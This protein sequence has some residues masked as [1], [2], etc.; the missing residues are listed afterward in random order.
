MIMFMLL[1]FIPSNIRSG[2]ERSEGT[3]HMARGKFI[4]MLSTCFTKNS[5][6][7]DS[8]SV[9]TI[10]SQNFLFYGIL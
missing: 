5:T 8:F 6:H 10:L 1:D 2:V 3:N 7:F 4:K 9:S